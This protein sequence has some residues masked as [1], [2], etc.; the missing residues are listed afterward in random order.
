MTSAPPPFQRLP[1]DA[2]PDPPRRPH[3]YFATAGR[4]VV[5]DSV[6]F[7]RIRIHV[8]EFGAGPPLL[9]VHGLMTSSYSYRYVL[10]ALGAHYRLVIP[11]LPGAGKSDKPDVPYTAEA[12]ATFVG[13][14][15]TALGLRGCA[16]VANSLGGHLCMRT[17]LRAPETFSRLVNIHSPGFPIGRLWALAAALSIPGAPALVRTTIARAPERWVWRNVHYHDE[18]LK[19]REETREYAAPLATA[20]GRVAFLRYLRET[21]APRPFGAFVDELRQRRQAGQPFPVPLML[22]FSRLDPLVPPSIGTRLHELIPEARMEWLA[23]TSHFAHVDSPDRV[24][25]LLLDFLRAA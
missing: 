17:A 5:V 20:E 21:M 4:D 14:L 2:L 23:D 7:G 13:E 22:L 18:T 15:V 8:R 6:P 1:F 10:D 16:C 24:V 3:P 25:P 11:D 12:L 19:S 9:L